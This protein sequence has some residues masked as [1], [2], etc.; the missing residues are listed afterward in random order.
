MNYLKDAMPCIA[1]NGT[2]ICDARKGAIIYRQDDPAAFRFEVVSGVIRTTYLFEDGRRQLTGFF[3]DGDVF[4]TDQGFYKASAEVVSET[5]EVQRIRWGDRD[6]DERALSQALELVENSVLL[7][8]RRTALSRVA[9][10]LADIRC[11]TGAKPQILLP[12]SRVDIA[13]YL[14]LTVETVSRTFSQLIRRRVIA[15]LDQ[16]QVRIIDQERLN[17]LAGVGI[18]PASPVGGED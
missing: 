10:F 5:A 18:G 13:D 9:A 8:G 4:G 17:A 2:P 6:A 1:D 15:Q 14:G 11:R 3:F 16:Q 12:M 7:L